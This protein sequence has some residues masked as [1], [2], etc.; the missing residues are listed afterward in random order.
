MYKRK[1]I[2]YTD[3]FRDGKRY[4]KSLK[5]SS[6]SIAKERE[7]KLIVDIDSGAYDLR[8]KREAVD[9]PFLTIINDYLLSESTEKKSHRRDKVAAVHIKK[10]FGNKGLTEITPDDVAKFRASRKQEL[11][12]KNSNKKVPREQT[13]FATINRELAL[14]RRIFNWHISRKR[15]SLDNPVK[16]TK[17][18]REQP[19]DRILTEDEEARLFTIGKPK[20]DLRDIMSFA[21][22]TGARKNEI[23]QL[24]KADLTI[25]ELGGLAIFR[26]TKNGDN[27]RVLLTKDIAAF[28]RGIIARHP[29]AENVFAHK[30]G[31]PIKSI[32]GAFRAACKRASIKDLRFHDFRHTFCTRMAYEGTNPFLIMQ[33][34]G[35]KDTATAKRYTNPADEQLL[36]AMD[37]VFQPHHFSQH[38]PL[39]STANSDNMQGNTVLTIS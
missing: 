37:K 6:R 26:D 20:P 17:F 34:V 2:Y 8:K 25:G 24:K 16:G 36:A 28:L 33:L 21:L 13:S 5:T 18:F 29:F 4:A 14:L 32:D 11:E 9:I 3:I 12:Y 23:L 10:F 27:R 39:D 22:W 35:H 38:T 15:I 1:N 31:A 7:R 30:N 19:R